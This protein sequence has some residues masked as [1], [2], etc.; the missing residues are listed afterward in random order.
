MRQMDEDEVRQRVTAIGISAEWL[1]RLK[2]IAGARQAR[3]GQL[4]SIRDVAESAFAAALGKE[5][6]DLDPP[7][8]DH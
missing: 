6:A 7:E 8:A 3:T 1:E 4:W 5:L 2:R